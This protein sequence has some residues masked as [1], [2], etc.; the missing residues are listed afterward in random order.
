MRFGAMNFPVRQVIQELREIAD[1]GFDYVEIAMDPP[2]SHHSSLKWIQ[3][4]LLSIL[5]ERRLDVIFHLPTFVSLADLTESIRTASLRE[6]LDSLEV[7]ADF[8]PLKVVL[9]PPYITGLGIFVSDQARKYGLECL[10]AIVSKADGL[11]LTLC[12][13][14]MFAKTHMLVEA[15]HFEDIFRR[16]PKLKF[17]LDTGHANIGSNG[18]RIFELISRFPDRLG[19][20]HASDNFGKEDNHLPIGAGT[21]DF[22]RIAKAL[23]NIGYDDT[24]TFEI[25]SRD[26]SYLV[27]SR[28]KFASMLSSSS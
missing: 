8:N 14:N 13:E 4:E 24:V 12:I 26:R 1:L 25:F 11:G 16:F 27:F 3:K 5:Q 28:E 21:V 7:A 20:V 17:T 9:H 6:V 19:H 22:T 2:E 10:D 23:K 15:D 18:K